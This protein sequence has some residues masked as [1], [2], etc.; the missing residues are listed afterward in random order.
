[1]EED[2]LVID[3][4]G[5]SISVDTD[6]ETPQLIL[7]LNSTLAVEVAKHIHNQSSPSDSW[8]INHNL[9]FKPSVQVYS[10]GSQLVF[11]NVLHLS[12]NQTMIYFDT[13]IAGYARLI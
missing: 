13:P 1:M 11:A 8:N 3:I 12:N 6:F 9:G 5:T 10:S 4:T 2:I 7:D